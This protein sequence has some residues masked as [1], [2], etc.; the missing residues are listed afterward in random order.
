MKKIGAQD[1]KIEVMPDKD[2]KNDFLAYIPQLDCWGDGKNPSEAI[3]EVID[4]GNDIIELAIEDGVKVPLPTSNN[5]HEEYSG[6]LSLRLPKYLHSE[7]A[8][9]AESENCSINQLIQSFIAM[10]IGM[11]YGEE[12][13]TINIGIDSSKLQK[14]VVKDKSNW[15]ED[16]SKRLDKKMVTGKC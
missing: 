15:F 12:K 3:K 8:K 11:K 9:R 7:I 4:V 2:N 5:L 1:Y 16:L 13:I 14:S 6:K 10:G